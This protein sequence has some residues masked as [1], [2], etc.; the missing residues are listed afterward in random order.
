MFFGFASSFTASR[1]A[2]VLNFCAGY[3]RVSR[4]VVG[5]KFGVVVM[6]FH[7]SITSTT[8]RIYEDDDQA[9]HDKRKPYNL[10]V[11]LEWL[12]DETVY[13]RELIGSGVDC[14]LYQKFKHF[15]KSRGVKTMMYER[16]SELKFEVL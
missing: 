10:K 2:F 1:S 3:L 14:A 9:A 8:V 7:E 4:F 16:H 5:L 13:V 15:L 11:N 6:L 12:N